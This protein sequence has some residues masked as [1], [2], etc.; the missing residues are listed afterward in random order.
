MNSPA[1]RLISK[2]APK[3]GNVMRSCAFG[4]AVLVLAIVSATRAGEDATRLAEG[5]ESDGQPGRWVFSN[6]AEFP[7]ARGSF[8]RSEEAAHR[9]EFGGCLQFDFTGGGAYV[10]AYLSVDS[11]QDLAAVRVCLKKPKDNSFTIRY[12]DQTDQ[13]FQKSVWVPD[14]RWVELLIPLTDWRGHWGGANDGQVHGPPKRI[15]FLIEDGGKKQGAL[16]FDDVRLVPEKPGETT[17]TS[18]SEYAAAQFASDEEWRLRT[19]G[20]AGDSSLEDRELRFDFSKGATTIGIVPQESSLLGSPQEIRIRVRGSAPGHPVRMQIA[21]HFMT[22]EKTV[23][24]FRGDDISEI[25]TEAPPGEGWRWYGGENDGKRHGALRIRGIHLDAAG[26]KDSGTLELLEIS[27]KTRCAADRCC[28]LTADCCQQ[29]DDRS[30]AATVR[31]LLPEPAAGKLRYVVRDWS[32]AQI[33]DGSAEVTIPAGGLPVVTAVAMPAG[34]FPFLEA[35]FSLE[36]PDQLVPAAR[37]YCTAP[38]EPHGS[39]E[40]DPSSPF[41]MGLY[42]YRYGNDPASLKTMDR[43]ARIACAAGVKWSREE[44]GWDRIE[45]Q[46]GK[47]DWSF[48]D[49]MVVTAKRHGISIYGLLAY[50]SRWT[51]PYTPEGIDA[52]CRFAAAAADR[53]RDD[54]QHWEVYN[55]PNIFFWQGPRDMYAELLKKAHAAIKNANPN[56]KVLGCST[57]GIDAKFIERTIELGAPFDILTIHP[58]RRRLEDRSFVQQLRDAAEVAK[59]PNGTI[60]PVWITEMGWAT[61]AWH[62]GTEAGFSV[63]TQR[64]QARLI[65][66]AYIGAIASGA[67]TNM[68]WYD[69]RNDG[70]DPFNFEHNLGIVTRDFWPKPAYRAYATVTRLLQGKSIDKELDLGMEVIAYRFASADRGE[71]VVAVWS[72]GDQQMVKL[73]AREP[74]T[75]VNLMGQENTVAPI[76]GDAEVP[77]QLETPVFVLSVP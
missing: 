54:I 46:E 48:F 32:G 8:Q 36:A 30:F 52:Y 39:A 62:N 69:F 59:A 73:P 17:G 14:D 60:R 21:T 9:G 27:V 70:M 2:Q 42:L 47:Y 31:G 55:E 12:T 26:K 63:T 50:W 22:F 43:A 76:D 77:L 29:D 24:E 49:N 65:A 3:K 5:F 64:E 6:G 61:H 66:R 51:K 67:V 19:G 25:V 7:G 44:F 20:P 72:I 37:A 1:A 34:D 74:V 71:F 15:G 68:S 58:Y 33:A 11:S 18:T 41:G 56:A 57:A 75:V 53:Y 13:T 38:I 28:V 23:G 16:L 35:E 10:A 45:V 4:F 40:L